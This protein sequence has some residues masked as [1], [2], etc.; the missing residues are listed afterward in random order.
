M[1]ASRGGL[2]WDNLLLGAAIVVFYCFYTVLL[3]GSAA[4]YSNKTLNNC[5][6]LAKHLHISEH[7]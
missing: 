6:S 2:L 1:Q 3:Q 4:I 5:V 7:L